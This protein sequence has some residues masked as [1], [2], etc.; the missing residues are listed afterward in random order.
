MKK[1]LFLFVFLSV[2]ITLI[3][4]GAPK[5]GIPVSI[6]APIN[7][8]LRNLNRYRQNYSTLHSFSLIFLSSQKL[9]S[10]VYTC[11]TWN[12]CED[13][14]LHYTP[15]TYLTFTSFVQ[16]DFRVLH[17]ISGFYT[18]FQGSTLD[19]RVLHLISGFYTWFQGS[20]HDFRVLHLIS[21]FYTWFQGSTLAQ[22]E[23]FIFMVK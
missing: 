19:F 5:H 18:W 8:C 22:A 17:L 12:L 6:L 1:K 10:E 15:T 2:F 20:T 21:G 4:L 11:A 13:I 14:I 23:I 9:I 3:D 7:P 16:L